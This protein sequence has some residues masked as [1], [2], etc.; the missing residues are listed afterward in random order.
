MIKTA[1]SEI[2]ARF[3][4]VH[5]KHLDRWEKENPVP[6]P[7]DGATIAKELRAGKFDVD[8]K[9]LRDG[10]K[11]GVRRNW[12]DDDW[13]N[14]LDVISTPSLKKHLAATEAREAEKLRF[15]EVVQDAKD[16]Y[17]D[18][19][20]FDHESGFVL[21]RDFQRWR[22]SEAGGGGAE[23]A[24]ERVNGRTREGYNKQIGDSEQMPE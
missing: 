19:V 4:T 16:A 12:R 24:R 11:N 21:L 13:I 20:L 7:P 14:F 18:R 15:A 6:P 10:M 8:E 1:A 3:A 2:K 17:L 5:K 9:V 22:E 23:P